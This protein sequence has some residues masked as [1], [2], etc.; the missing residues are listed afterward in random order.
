MKLSQ[1]CVQCL[2]PL[3]CCFFS[4]HII[5]VMPLICVQLEQLYTHEIIP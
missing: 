5:I 2:K 4:S 1:E 3:I